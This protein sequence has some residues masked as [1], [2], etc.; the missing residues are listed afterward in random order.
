[1]RLCVAIARHHNGAGFVS[2]RARFPR[3]GAETAMRFIFGLIIGS[4]LTVGGAYVSDKVSSAT[5]DAKPMVNW[6]VVAKNWDHVT[7]LARES[8][9]KITG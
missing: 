8:W 2:Y 5:P 6:D 7:T 1:M 3:T 9:K 4:L